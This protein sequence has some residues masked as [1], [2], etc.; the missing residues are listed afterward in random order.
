MTLTGRRY[1][2]VSPNGRTSDRIALDM[3]RDS[4]RD[5]RTKTIKTLHKDRAA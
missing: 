1:G 5:G 4:Q 3:L 2:A